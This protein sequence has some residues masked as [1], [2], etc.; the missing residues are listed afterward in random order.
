MEG[1][2]IIFSNRT[3]FLAH[4][5]LQNLKKIKKNFVDTAP[6]HL[7]LDMAPN[8]Y[9]GVLGPATMQKRLQRLQ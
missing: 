3:V 5:N 7:G 4:G 8:G 2:A 9:A 6:L 1:H